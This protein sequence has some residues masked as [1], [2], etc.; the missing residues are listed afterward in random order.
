VDG[1]D[2]VVIFGI[3]KKRASQNVFRVMHIER[4]VP[5]KRR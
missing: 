5:T 4:V 2:Y 1:H 3:D